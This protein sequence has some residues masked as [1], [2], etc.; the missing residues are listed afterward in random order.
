MTM[1]KF[2]GNI[3]VFV[4]DEFEC[5]TLRFIAIVLFT[6]L[7]QLHSP[8]HVSYLFILFTLLK[9]WRAFDSS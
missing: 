7:S 3:F 2:L 8:D 4:L 6:S 1:G 5:Y 9:R